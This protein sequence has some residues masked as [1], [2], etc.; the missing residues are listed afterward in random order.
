MCV[1]A[2]KAGCCAVRFEDG[3]TLTGSEDAIVT[4]VAAHGPNP[5]YGLGH[6]PHST[7]SSIKT[8]LHFCCPRLIARKHVLGSLF[9]DPSPTVKVM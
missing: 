2:H 3:Q 9:N 5:S 1:A 8:N 7:G 4:A 6:L